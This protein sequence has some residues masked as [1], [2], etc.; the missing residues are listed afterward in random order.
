MHTESKASQEVQESWVNSPTVQD[1][2]L[3]SNISS[4]TDCT[5]TTVIAISGE[6]QVILSK[7]AHYGI[8][9]MESLQAHGLRFSRESFSSLDPDDV[10][11][12]LKQQQK[13]LADSQGSK[14]EGNIITHCSGHISH[15]PAGVL[16]QSCKLAACLYVLVS[17]SNG[18]ANIN[19]TTGISEL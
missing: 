12:F 9:L 8:P 15:L 6:Y 19:L 4:H 1:V 5:L 16:L 17:F 10:K 13:R 18:A 3:N 14:E 11:F 7:V 2:Y